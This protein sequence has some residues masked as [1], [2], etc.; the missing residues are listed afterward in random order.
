[1][2]KKRKKEI[3][4]KGYIK[5]FFIFLIILINTNNENPIHI[6]MVFSRLKFYFCKKKIKILFIIFYGDTHYH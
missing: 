2:G 6:V 3:R 1:M 4:R 5:D